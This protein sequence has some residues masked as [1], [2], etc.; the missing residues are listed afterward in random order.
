MQV[1]RVKNLPANAGDVKRH[2]FDP[3]VG[4]IPWRRAWQPTCLEN[5][6]DRGAWWAIVHR[7]AELDTTQVTKQNSTWK[8]MVVRTK[9]DVVNMSG[10]KIYFE[11]RIDRLSAD[12]MC[13]IRGGKLRVTSRFLA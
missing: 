5:A 12:W 3:W 4:K 2:G 8:M 6:M 11:D 9:V 10:V 1:L 13:R 7:T